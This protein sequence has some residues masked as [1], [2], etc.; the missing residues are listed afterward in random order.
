MRRS[1][2]ERAACIEDL[3]QLARRRIPKFAYEYLVNGCNSNCAVNSNRQALDALHLFPR[4][5]TDCPE[6]SLQCELMGQTYAA[7]FG[8]APVGLSG[9][10]WPGASASQARVA[11]QANIPFVLSSLASISIEQAAELAQEN[12]W[13]QFYPPTVKEIS[14][15]LMARAWNSGCRHLVVTIDVPSAGY[16][17]ADIRNGLSVPPKIS[18][19][20]IWQSICRPA[21]SLATVR[22]GIPQFASMQ[23]YIPADADLGNVAHYIRNTLKKVVD[24]STLASIRKQWQGKLIVK[25]I[26]TAEDAKRAIAAEA[27]GLII[28]NHGGR[29]LDAAVPSLQALKS[30]RSSISR[31]TALMVDG[32][33]ESGV[34][35]ARYLACGADAVFAGRAFMYGVAG[36]G[37]DGADYTAALLRRE[38]QQVMEQLR[39]PT[40]ADLPRFLK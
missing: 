25:G 39:C 27:D 13:F 26:L 28:S 23:P 11:H 31:D 4:Y 7:P 33:V 36:L 1:F 8:V 10:I 37:N 38:L 5:L 29:Q 2:S 17:P 18:A 24:M 21:W 22:H 20:N 16:R 30:I 9:L 14:T 19:R 32:G 3:K 40:I 34:D 12:F 35:I 15:D 6:S